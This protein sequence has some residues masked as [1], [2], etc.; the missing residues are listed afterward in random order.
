MCER[1]GPAGACG[2]ANK[3]SPRTDFPEGLR[4]GLAQSRAPHLC[5][6]LLG[7]PRAISRSPHTIIHAINEGPTTPTTTHTAAAAAGSGSS[8][9]G[10]GPEGAGGASTSDHKKRRPQRPPFL[11]ALLTLL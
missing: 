6:G 1:S 9:R 11:H 10:A 3:P 8:S 5:G 4:A 7:L 2:H